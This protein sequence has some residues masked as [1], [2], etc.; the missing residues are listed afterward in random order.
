MNNNIT[1]ILTVIRYPVGGI[2]TYLK[3]TYGHLDPS[4]YEFTFLTVRN[5]EAKIIKEDLK[6][7]QTE[8]IEVQEKYYLTEFLKNLI[9]LLYKKKFEV[10]HSHGFIAAVVAIL[11]NF[12]FRVPHLVTFHSVFLEN[13]Q[14]LEKFG[15]IKRY[16]LGRLLSFAD[17]IQSVSD[18]AEENLIQNLPYLSKFKNKLVVIQNGISIGN[19]IS[20]TQ[21]IDNDIR[22]EYKIGL[23][24]TLF[25]FLGRFMPQ[26]GF[27]YLIDAVELLSQ[28]RDYSG[29]FK[30]LT[31]NDGAYLERYKKIIEHKNLSGY[32]VYYGFTS[33]IVSVLHELDAVVIPS[34]WEAGPLLPMEAFVSGCPVIATQCIGLRQVIANSPA[35]I[36]KHIKDPQA[37]ADSLKYFIDHM[38]EIRSE[39]STFSQT[40][41]GKFDVRNAS[42]KLDLIFDKLKGHISV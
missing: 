16:F 41:I 7:F 29:A 3:Y 36:I 39:C 25:G 11:V 38:E 2:R 20:P 32:F 8:V 42:K 34:I 31:V 19:F 23:D 24:V 9:S 35:I 26:K 37:V 40:A 5:Y 33:N 10:I 27:N 1:K 28:D 30:I 4:K 15:S 6:N 22:E 14:F 18:D 21:G 12:I 17:L 13:D